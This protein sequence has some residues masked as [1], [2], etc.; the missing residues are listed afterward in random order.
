MFNY[1]FRDFKFLTF[2]LFIGSSSYCQVFASDNIK[3]F[4]D[5]ITFF[6]VGHG[7]AALMHKGG[8][9]PD[10]KQPYV[11]LLIDAGSNSRSYRQNEI[12][13]WEKYEI[14]SISFNI[15]EKI[16]GYWKRNPLNKPAE[17]IQHLNII[18]THPDKD[19][20]N[21]VP[22][23]LEQIEKKVKNFNISL[24]LG[25]TENE[26][27]EFYQELVEKK[28]ATHYRQKHYV[29]ALNASLPLLLS[30]LNTQCP[31]FNESGCITHFF[32]RKVKMIIIVGVL[33]SALR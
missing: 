29:T 33:L 21:F 19:H 27:L 32:A 26:Y 25:G 8:I 12:Y 28:L 11:P 23:I 16:I 31:P 2:F 20:K 30:D 13:E 5:E 24:I 22:E 6:N 17:E 14:D 15:S 3:S 18:I 9:N 1:F 7:H 4:E 10:T